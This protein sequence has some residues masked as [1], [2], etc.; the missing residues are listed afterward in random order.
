MHKEDGTIIYI[1][2]SKNIKK[3][4]TQHF[5]NDNR[6]SKNIQEE[7]THITYE[8]TG[9]ELMALLKENEEIKQNKPKYNRSLKRTKFDQAL[10]QFTDENGYINLKFSK[11]DGRKTSITTFTNRQQAKSFMYR[12]TEEYHLCQRMMGLDNGKG[13]CFNYTIKKCDGA[14]SLNEPVETYNKRAQ[15]LIS[16]H[17]FDKKDIIVIDRGRDVDEQSVLL[18]EKGK[19]RGIGYFNLNHQVNNID[20]LKSII[21]PMGHNRD[22]QHIIQSYIRTHKKLKVITLDK[23]KTHTT[24]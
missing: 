11:I 12:W 2:K 24:G 19:F 8:I 3:R 13:N 10:Y 15:Q 20:I 14:C 7:V 4:V 9:S 6:K 18:I 21:T 16:N 17:S 1:G 22:A 5:T 23:N